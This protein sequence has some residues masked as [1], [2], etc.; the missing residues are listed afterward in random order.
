MKDNLI[1]I[2]Q[3]KPNDNT[4]VKVEPLVMLRRKRKEYRDANRD[5]INKWKREDYR[6]NK[7]KILLQQ[8]QHRDE[9]RAQHP[10]KRKKVVKLTDSPDYNKNYRDRNKERLRARDKEYYEGNKIALKKKS[11]KYYEENKEK[12]LEKSKDATS[13]IKALIRGRGG[14][15]KHSEIPKELVEI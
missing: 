3:Q 9:Y 7:D 12:I 1:N 11:K 15:L 13:A 8:K 6:K 2:E 5:R 10:D 14:I 4:F